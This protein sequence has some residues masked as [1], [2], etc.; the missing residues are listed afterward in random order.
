[1][2]EVRRIV[3]NVG[4]DEEL[5]SC[6]SWDK[7]V[8]YMEHFFFFFVKNDLKTNC[9][10]SDLGMQQTF[11]LKNEQSELATLRKIVTNSILARDKI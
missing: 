5:Y 11:F 9:G 7:L 6:G 1:M 3:P 8:T 10:Y 4:K 2:A